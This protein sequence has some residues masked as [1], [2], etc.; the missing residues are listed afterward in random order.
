MQKLDSILVQDS[1]FRF[2]G[3]EYVT[4]NVI[5]SFAQ[6]LVSGITH[7]K[8]WAVSANVGIVANLCTRTV[9]T[10]VK[11]TQIYMLY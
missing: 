4:E 3:S 1:S 9:K 10:E 5:D 2:R 7:Q 11:H 8:A 6:I